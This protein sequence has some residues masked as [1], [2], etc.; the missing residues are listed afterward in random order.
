M[1]HRLDPVEGDPY[2]P[3]SEVVRRLASEFRFV[4]ADPEAG[5]GHV[6]EM[7]RQF[8]RMSFPGE[9][10]EDHRRRQAEAVR[11]TVADSLGVADECLSF[12]AMPGAG[13]FV[14]YHSAAHERAAAP[15]VERCGRALGYLV[16]LC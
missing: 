15:L 6:A 2:L 12:V 14:G 4:T 11:V 3:P 8:E 9:V 13:L 16:T 5:A 10:I 7:I 1:A